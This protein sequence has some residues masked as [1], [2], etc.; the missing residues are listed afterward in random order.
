[1][2][3]RFPLFQIE[4]A[5]GPWFSPAAK[6]AASISVHHHRKSWKT[7]RR[8]GRRPGPHPVIGLK[9]QTWLVPVVGLGSERI[10]PGS[11]HRACPRAR[12]NLDPS[13]FAASRPCHPPDLQPSPTN[14]RF[15]LFYP[16]F[17]P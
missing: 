11:R 8:P 13:F 6:L 10:A 12:T 9:A 15:P 2:A 16:C 17:L 4:P 3:S 7:N 5:P 14:P 1:L